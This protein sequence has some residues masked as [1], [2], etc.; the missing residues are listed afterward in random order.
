MIM[1]NRMNAEITSLNGEKLQRVILDNDEPDRLAG[2]RKA[3]FHILQTRKREETRVIRVY[4]TSVESSS[5]QRKA[6]CKHLRPSCDV[7]MNKSR[8]MKSV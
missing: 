1:L 6:S 5:R 3:F 4:R 2:E 7:N 8:W